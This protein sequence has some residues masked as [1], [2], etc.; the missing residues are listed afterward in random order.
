MP[1]SATATV[2]DTAVSAV[3]FGTATAKVAV[4]AGS[5]ALTAPTARVQVEPAGAP[6]RQDQP[7]VDPVVVKV[8]PTGTVSV[9]TT[10]V[11]S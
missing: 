5:S 3:G 1:S 6:G 10:P 2:L 4:C 11:A 9:S 7:A 8:V